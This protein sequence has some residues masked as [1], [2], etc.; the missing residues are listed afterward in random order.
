MIPYS[1]TVIFYG[2]ADIQEVPSGTA[3]LE[4]CL[5]GGSAA[6]KFLAGLQVTELASK[7]SEAAP[8]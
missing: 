3:P 2:A 8:P 7:F 1:I 4:I 6:S 5:G